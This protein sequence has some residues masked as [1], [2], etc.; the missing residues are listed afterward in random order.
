MILFI[1]VACLL[2]FTSVAPDDSNKQGSLV[3]KGVRAGNFNNHRA[4]SR[5]QTSS[6]KVITLLKPKPPNA[7]P[8][9]SYNFTRDL[10]MG[11]MTRR[12]SVKATFFN[13]LMYKYQAPYLTLIP[14]GDCSLLIKDKHIWECVAKTDNDI[15]L[16]YVDKPTDDLPT[17]C[18]QYCVNTFT[19]RWQVVSMVQP[20]VM[21]SPFLGSAE[22]CVQTAT[23]FNCKEKA[24]EHYPMNFP[25]ISL[26]GEVGPRAYFFNSSNI[27][28]C[29]GSPTVCAAYRILKQAIY[30]GNY[31]VS[32]ADA[33]TVRN[34]PYGCI[35]TYLGAGDIESVDMCYDQLG[36]RTTKPGGKSNFR[37][38]RDVQEYGITNLGDK[39]PP[40]MVLCELSAGVYQTTGTYTFFKTVPEGI[41]RCQAVF[42]P[43][44]ILNFTYL[45]YDN[46]MLKQLRIL[47]PSVILTLPVTD[48]SLFTYALTNDIVKYV[49]VTAV[50]VA[51][52]GIMLDFTNLNVYS[53]KLEDW[54]K[55]VAQVLKLYD[56][57]TIT[58]KLPFD[59]VILAQIK[60]NELNPDVSG[61]VIPTDRLGLTT[62]GNALR[63]QMW[64]G[65]SAAVDSVFSYITDVMKRVPK[66]LIIVGLSLSGQMIVGLRKARSPLSK[67]MSAKMLPMADIVSSGFQC[68]NEGTSYCCKGKNYIVERTPSN[69]VYKEVITIFTT[70]DYLLEQVNLI[71]STFGLNKISLVDADT[72]YKTGRENLPVVEMLSSAITVLPL[73]R[74]NPTVDPA[75]FSKTDSERHKRDVVEKQLYRNMKVNYF[76]GTNRLLPCAGQV[77]VYGTIFIVN[78]PYVEFYASA[79]FEDIYVATTDTLESCTPGMPTNRLPTTTI[80][81]AQGV[82][83]NTML[84]S[85]E[86]NQYLIGLDA[87]GRLVEYV[88]PVNAVCQDVNSENIDRLQYV[89]IDERVVFSDPQINDELGGIAIIP[90][91]VHHIMS[92]FTYGVDYINFNSICIDYDVSALPSCFLTVCGGDKT[93]LSDRRSPCKNSETILNDARRSGLNMRAAFE[94]LN[95][96]ERK[97]KV[98]EMPN[99]VMKKVKRHKRFVETIILAGAVAVSMAMSVTALVIAEQTSRRLDLVDQR[100]QENTNQ[101]MNIGGQLINVTGK[102]DKN[103]ELTNNRI[104]EMQTDMNKR[105]TVI[106]S[107]FDRLTK[108][109]RALASSTSAGFSQM[110]GYQSW[111]SQV[112]SI[113]N[114]LTQGAMQITYKALNTQAC[115]SQLQSGK[116]GSCPSGLEVMVNHP[117]ISAVP[118]VEGLLYRD[119]KLFIVN[120]VP[121][122]IETVVMHKVIGKPTISQNVTCWP[123]YDVWMY[124]NKFYLPGKCYEKYCY[125]FTRHDRFYACLADTSQCKVLC[126]PCYK[127][128][129]YNM[130]SKEYVFDMGTVVT[131]IVG[132]PP[133]EFYRPSIGDSVYQPMVQINI[134]DAEVIEVLNNSVVLVDIH[135]DIRGMEQSLADYKKRIEAIGTMSS[136]SG[137]FNIALTVMLVLFTLW[138][139]VLTFLYCKQYNV[140]QS[141]VQRYEMLQ[142]DTRGL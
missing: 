97:A 48:A 24:Y 81:P 77:G 38:T 13:D 20:S 79:M 76:V 127:N 90:N 18:T 84:A 54:V 137:T 14:T 109:F 112:S 17:M 57:Y 35:L 131:N 42:V 139:L 61:Y 21:I 51:S 52:S 59:K 136:Y 133:K 37:V 80:P 64:R 45:A 30:G 47:V 9:N 88:P 118:T 107:N 104:S 25:S 67:M 124:N 106:N 49:A 65:D 33:L 16:A 41:A 132:S 71:S 55:K 89:R 108:E 92:N 15:A 36:P 29:T 117:G 94:Q 43:P 66:E 74:A 58:I 119:R 60:Y 68:Q 93:C 27:A 125:E 135:E 115:L 31:T 96:E 111:L 1:C 85:V 12:Q 70:P 140:G 28:E 128:V 7:E 34:S 44:Q 19:A 11:N 113:T 8:S 105:F 73:M 87:D 78:R 116:M 40:P 134:T 10:I 50:S 2:F 5:S 82:N 56:I 91:G 72:D 3:S 98:Y 86:K 102:L 123:D 63:C 121:N 62:A 6:S 103:I 126:A 120:R 142:R 39:H 99:E 75:V 114:Q 110:Y 138:L 141:N 100:A 130:D 26:Y 53:D 122:N 83:V 46:G 95:I 22:S 23:Q 129:C 101:I 69:I 32:D 4:S